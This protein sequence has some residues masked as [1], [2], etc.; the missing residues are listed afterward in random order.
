MDFGTDEVSKGPQ[1]M[2]DIHETASQNFNA[3]IYFISFWDLRTEAMSIRA[4]RDTKVGIVNRKRAE[5]AGEV[6][7]TGRCSRFKFYI[8]SP[9]NSTQR[10]DE[11]SRGLHPLNRDWA[12]ERPGDSRGSCCCR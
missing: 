2:D 10:V 8:R 4:R 7:G 12:N 9:K 6:E 3:N 1:E 11:I 5:G